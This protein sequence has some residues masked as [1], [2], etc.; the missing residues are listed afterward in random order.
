M[1]SEPYGWMAKWY[2]T[3][4]EPVLGHA[5]RLGLQMYT[6]KPGQVVL[7]VG[8][9]T[10][11]QLALYQGLG[12]QLAG[13]DPAPAMVARAEE[14]LGSSAR[15]HFGS[16]TDISYPDASV[17]LILFSMMLHELSREARAAVLTEARRVL[18]D[19]GRILVL[20]Y[21]PGPL[22]FPRGYA[23]KPLIL[24]V[25]RMA[26][27]D[28]FRHCREFLAEGGLP[29]AVVRHGLLVEVTKVI[30]GGNF[31][32]FLLRSHTGQHKPA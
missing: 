24:A 12:C 6:P 31:G 7:D 15:I 21:H 2:D 26:G 5:K 23:A 20:D 25:E 9:G 22:T 17:H 13:I 1:A 10:G 3:V 29:A 32:L 27:R 14:K 11:T 18:A 16:A 4:F 19:D 28:H 8:C 30:K